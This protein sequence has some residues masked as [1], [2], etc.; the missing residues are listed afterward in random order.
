VHSN[1]AISNFNRPI[2]NPGLQR[3]VQPRVVTQGQRW[4]Q[5]RV[6]TQGQRWTR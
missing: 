2:A 5:P 4:V 1:R 6:V 3:W